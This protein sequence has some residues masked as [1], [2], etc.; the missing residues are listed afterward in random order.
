MLLVLDRERTKCGG[1]SWLQKLALSPSTEA[2]GLYWETKS[3]QKLAT[4]ALARASAI[5]SN[6]PTLHVLLGDIYRQRKYY[7]DAEQEY[8][9]ALAIQPRRCGCLVRVCL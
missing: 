6:S 8:R 5:N 4:E 3:A 2:E 1:R 9:K 7:P